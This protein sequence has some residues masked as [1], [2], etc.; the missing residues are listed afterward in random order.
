MALQKRWVSEFVI[1][2]KE[3][4]SPLVTYPPGTPVYIA[5][6]VERE[7][8]RIECLLIEQKK[9]LQ[10]FKD[11]GVTEAMLRKQDGFLKLGLGCIVVLASE[12]QTMNRQLTEATALVR[13][14]TAALNEDI[15]IARKEL[16][17]GRSHDVLDLPTQHSA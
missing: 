1:H 14:L 17:D 7:L 10:R 2:G 15:A 3:A 9:E 4:L 16:V 11:G 5:E 6:E 12:Y 13:D 8:A